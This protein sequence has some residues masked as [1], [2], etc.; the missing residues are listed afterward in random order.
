MMIMMRMMTMAMII[1]M[2]TTTMMKNRDYFK[3]NNEIDF[4][5]FNGANIKNNKE[6][7][8]ILW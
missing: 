7:Y 6:K 5:G 3:D 1:T 8:T 4:E 2:M